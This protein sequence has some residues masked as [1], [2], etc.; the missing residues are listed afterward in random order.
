MPNKI[1]AL[2]PSFSQKTATSLL[3]TLFFLLLTTSTPFVFADIPRSG[4][5]K[6][7]PQ[8]QEIP[9]P[10]SLEQAIALAKNH[11][12]TKLGLQTQ[13]LFPSSMPIFMDCQRLTFNNTHSIDN[14]R[15][16]INSPLIAPHHQQ[17]L[18][19]LQ[20]FFD[21]LLAD[22]NNGFINEKMAGSYIRYDRA[23]NRFELKQLSERVVARLEAEYQIVLQQF[24]ASEATQRISRS[25]LAQA[26]NTPEQLPSDLTPPDL[27]EVPDEL[28]ELDL[29]YQ[30]AI[31]NNDWLSHLKKQF[32]NEDEKALTSLIQMNLRQQILEL[33]LRLQVLKSAKQQA[34]TENKLREL[35]LDMSRALYD[36]EVKADLGNSMTLQSKAILEE[37][38]I[39]YCQ[40]LSWAQLNALQGKSILSP[41][42]V[43]K[44]DENKTEN[45]E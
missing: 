6:N 26:L 10:L 36:M 45:N 2:N 22:L 37:E 11:P 3:R 38:R 23:K 25:T 20:A 8:Q 12:R 40:Y 43:N 29:V 35:N 4:D 28:P 30:Q 14:K 27:F 13:Q 44:N 5:S 31:K 21:V 34:E 32:P 17:Q 7:K 24:R 9:S 33:L 42:P 1:M 15:N 16:S 18:R 19:I 41:P 39:L